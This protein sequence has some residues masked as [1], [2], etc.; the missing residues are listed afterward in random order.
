M[1]AEREPTTSRPSVEIAIGELVLH[2]FEPGQRHGIGDTVERELARM[3]AAGGWN[4]GETGVRKLDGGVIELAA[5]ATAEQIGEQIA[6]AIYAACA[7][8]TQ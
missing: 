6:A 5:G 3:V 2:G 4:S 7:E 8:Q 1:N